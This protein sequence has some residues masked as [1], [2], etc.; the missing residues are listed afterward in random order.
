MI[1]INNIKKSENYF[2]TTHH[3]DSTVSALFTIDCKDPNPS[4]NSLINFPK[5]TKKVCKILAPDEEFGRGSSPCEIYLFPDGTAFWCAGYDNIF[6]KSEKIYK[7]DLELI[8]DVKKALI[9]SIG[10]ND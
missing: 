3:N 6:R 2:Y 9:K 10:W 5:G 7:N 8:S 4:G 1:K